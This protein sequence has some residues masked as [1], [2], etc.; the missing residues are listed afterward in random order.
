MILF[1][2]VEQVLTMCRIQ[3]WQHSASYFLSYFP[4]IVSDSISFPLDNLKT[5]WYIII[6]FYSYVEHI[7][8]MCRVQQWQMSPT[9]FLSYSPSMVSDAISCPLHNLKTLWYIIIILYSYV[10]HILM[11]C[12]V[13]QWQLARLLCL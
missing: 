6:I 13:Q 2:Y 12:R 7:L 9:T 4:L 10:E 5:L 8:M 1:S 11:M 3:D